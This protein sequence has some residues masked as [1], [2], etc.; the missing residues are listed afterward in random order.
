MKMDILREAHYVYNFERELYFN[1]EARKAFSFP[2]I[3]EHS[4]LELTRC[5]REGSQPSDEWQFYFNC[6]PTDRKKRELAS[7]LG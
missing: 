6:P 4:E 7:L 2:F 5:I 3:D 1:R